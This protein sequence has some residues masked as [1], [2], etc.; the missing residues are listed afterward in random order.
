MALL[1]GCADNGTPQCAVGADCASGMCRADGSCVPLDDD[2]GPGPVDAGE[3]TDA[4]APGDGGV[5]PMNDGGADVDGGGLCA[6]NHD[7]TITASEIP[8][9]AGLRA[10]FRVAT[11]VTFDTAGEDLGGGRRRWDLTG[12]FP[13]DESQLVETRD[14]AGAWYADDFPGASYVTELSVESDLLGVFAVEADSLDLLGVVSP[15]EGFTETHLEN[16]PA[17]PALQFPLALGDSWETTTSVSGLASGVGSFYTETYESEVDRAGEL[18]TSF[19]TFEVLRIRTELTRTV[20]LAVTTVVTFA[21]VAECFGTVAQMRGQ[22]YDTD[23]E[24]GELAELRRL[25]P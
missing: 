1:G 17:V 23:Q 11:D 12:P 25:V 9:R 10:T 8:L 13:G 3:G 22:D 19:G 21:F 20:G 24:L 16:D 2:A 7:G 5:E 15:E 18:V 4:S 14:P 6:P